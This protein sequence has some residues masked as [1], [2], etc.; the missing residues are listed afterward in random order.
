MLDPSK[1][2]KSRIR[3]LEP[4]SRE[5][6]VEHDIGSCDSGRT[7]RRRRGT[8][9]PLRDRGEL[10]RLARPKGCFAARRSLPRDRPASQCGPPRAGSDGRTKPLRH[11]RLCINSPSRATPHTPH[12]VGGPIVSSTRGP[13][14]AWFR[15][16][17]RSCTDVRMSSGGFMYPCSGHGGSIVRWP[18]NRDS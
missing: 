11:R 10:P 6:D 7:C 16:S 9:S 5:K 4:S 3:R 15:F 13:R 12:R 18:G 14:C 1:D 8:T 2:P 17:E